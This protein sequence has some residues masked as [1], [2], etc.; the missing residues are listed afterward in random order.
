MNSM[1]CIVLGPGP[2]APPG[3]PHPS[4]NWGSGPREATQGKSE[5]Q[6]AAPYALRPRLLAS[7]LIELSQ[8]HCMEGLTLCPF[9]RRRD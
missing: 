5:T 8:L 1:L 9:S 7:R 6:W 3:L 4:S 2:P